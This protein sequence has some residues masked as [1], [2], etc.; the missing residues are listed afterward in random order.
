MEGDVPCGVALPALAAD[1]LCCSYLCSQ[2]AAD[3]DG[4]LL[5]FLSSLCKMSGPV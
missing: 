2:L 5:V 1:L 4:R 3:A